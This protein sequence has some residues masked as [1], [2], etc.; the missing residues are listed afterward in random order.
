VFEGLDRR[1]TI[2]SLECSARLAEVYDR[3]A[4]PV[5]RTEEG[6]SHVS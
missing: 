3:V 1:L 5:G 2:S 4:F 6:A